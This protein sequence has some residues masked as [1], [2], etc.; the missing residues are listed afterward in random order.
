MPKTPGI[1]PKYRDI[2]DNPINNCALRARYG[3]SNRIASNQKIYQLIES[4]KFHIN[5]INTGPTNFS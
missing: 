5:D 3:V 1:Q 2:N 4:I